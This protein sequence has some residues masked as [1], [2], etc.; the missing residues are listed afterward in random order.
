LEPD[1][2]R[3]STSTLSEASSVLIELADVGL[4]PEEYEDQVRSFGYD[5]VRVAGLIAADQ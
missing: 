3:W 2:R 5:L 1:Q 4:L